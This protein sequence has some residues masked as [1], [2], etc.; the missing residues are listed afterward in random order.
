[1]L[2][3]G[4]LWR[5]G[6]WFSFKSL[7]TAACGGPP[8]LASTRLLGGR[9]SWPLAG[10]KPALLKHHPAENPR[11]KVHLKIPSLEGWPEGPGWVPFVERCQYGETQSRQIIAGHFAHHVLCG[12]V[13]STRAG[14][15]LQAKGTQYGQSLGYPHIGQ[16][17]HAKVCGTE[18]PS[19]RSLVGNISGALG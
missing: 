16:V 7:L 9:P 1:M 11:N 10:W 2:W 6:E 3:P 13:Y 18:F 4:M 15:S 5:I 14:E 19:L 17:L 8:S 12:G